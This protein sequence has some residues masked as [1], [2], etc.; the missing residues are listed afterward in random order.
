MSL[1]LTDWGELPRWWYKIMSSVFFS[2]LLTTQE[3]IKVVFPVPV[4]PTTA[5]G[6]SFF[7]F[8]FIILLILSDKIFE[9]QS[10]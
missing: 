2:S 5:R 4:S 7:Y 10:Q 9:E 3:E 1:W 8:Y 6:R